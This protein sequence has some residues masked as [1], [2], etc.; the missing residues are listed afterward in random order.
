MVNSKKTLEKQ[1]I[2]ARSAILN[3]ERQ[4]NPIVHLDS[5]ELDTLIIENDL[6]VMQFSGFSLTDNN[7]TKFPKALLKYPHL[8]FID[9]SDNHIEEIPPEISRLESLET[10][11]LSGNEIKEIPETLKTLPNLRVLNLGGNPIEISG[12]WRSPLYLAKLHELIINY[13]SEKS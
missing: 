2:E 1:K 13:F 11:D 5:R 12:D 4:W 10:L 8:E 9:L 7:F 3:A 6:N